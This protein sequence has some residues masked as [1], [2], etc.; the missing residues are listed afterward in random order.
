LKTKSQ[1]TNYDDL[2]IKLLKHL[3]DKFSKVSVQNLEELQLAYFQSDLE[4][5]YMIDMAGMAMWRMGK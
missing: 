4:K 5:Y 2:L 1:K 3:F